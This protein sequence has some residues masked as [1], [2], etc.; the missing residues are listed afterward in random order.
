MYRSFKEMLLEANTEN[1]LR[2]EFPDVRFNISKINSQKG[3]NDWI[4]LSILVVQYKNRNKGY[5]SEFMKR[6]VELADQE[7]FDI[8]LTPDDSY[9]EDE[10]MNK[11]QL[12][13]WYKKF[14]FE[15]KHKDDFRSQNTFCYYS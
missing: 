11:A 6:F 2:T 3:E 4:V 8:F 14:G 12:T 5:G 7:K 10:D 15:K 13:K 9:A 1:I